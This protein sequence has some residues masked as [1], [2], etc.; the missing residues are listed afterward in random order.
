MF[1]ARSTPDVTREPQTPLSSRGGPWRHLLQWFLPSPCLGC[2][3]VVWEPRGSLGL[4]LR[5]RGALVRW[6]QSGC[7]ICGKLLGAAH[8]PAGYR[9]GD[10]RRRR[11]PAD[12]VVSTWCYQPPLDKVVAGLKFRRLEYLGDHLGRRLGELF[13]RQVGGC[14]LVV[15]VPLHWRRRLSRGYNQA[16]VIARPLARTL[17][18]PVASVLRRR[19]GRFLFLLQDFGPYSIA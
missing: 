5:C 14:D 3:E 19:R 6:P 2:K 7:A 13:R 4:C 9:C 17:G 11:P 1:Y 8:M 12:R 10:C 15:P 18:L 16:A